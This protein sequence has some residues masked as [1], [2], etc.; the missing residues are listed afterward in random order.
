[1]TFP[2]QHNCQYGS[3]YICELVAPFQEGSVVNEAAQ[4]SLL[5]FLGKASI[6]GAGK[7]ISR[8]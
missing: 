2:D 6:E 5:F 1:M 4:A 3:L 8:F 7:L